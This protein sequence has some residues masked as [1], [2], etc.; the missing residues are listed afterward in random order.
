V[1][2]RDDRLKRVSLS[3][4]RWGQ[5]TFAGPAA[6]MVRVGMVQ[7]ASCGPAAAARRGA[8]GVAS[9]DP[10]SE[11][12]AGSVAILGLVVTARSA[13]DRGELGDVQEFKE[14]AKR[15]RFR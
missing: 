1:T 15:H 6:L 4:A 12:A 13:D 8:R 9:F 7:V 11:L 3:F 2:N 14:A 5:I 10:V